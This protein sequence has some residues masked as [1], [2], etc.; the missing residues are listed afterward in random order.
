[1]VSLGFAAATAVAVTLAV[2]EASGIRPTSYATKTAYWDQRPTAYSDPV[3]LFWKLEAEVEALQ[4]KLLQVQQVSRHGTRYDVAPL[5]V[6]A[7]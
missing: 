4:L 3:A 1:M 5:S 7:F 6:H 2:S